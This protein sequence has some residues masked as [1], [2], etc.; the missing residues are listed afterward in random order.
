MG[1]EHP[2]WD[3]VAF[4]EYVIGHAR[5]A[6]VATDQASLA[7]VT[8]IDSGLLGRYFRGETQ[9]GDKNLAKIHGAVPGT[10]MRELLVLAGRARADAIGL[11]AVPAAPVP[12]L[13]P[14]AERVDHLLSDSSHLTPPER[15]LLAELI[16]HVLSRY[17]Q[18]GRRSATA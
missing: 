7:K 14:V 12:T 1:T 16:S 4:R 11:R 5:N 9:P 2:E 8:G 15:T 13:H 18:D 6:R 10:S 3:S 17:D